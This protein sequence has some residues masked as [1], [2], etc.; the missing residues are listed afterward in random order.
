MSDGIALLS[1][2]DTHCGST[3]GLMPPE[4]V[5]LDDGGFYFPSDAQRWLWDKF[6]E[7]REA[8]E[9][10]RDALKV[11]VH[12][13]L[14]GDVTDG[15]HH[16][17]SQIVS[18][19]PN[20]QMQIAKDSL[21]HLLDMGPRT[22]TVVRGTEVHV[23]PSGSVEDSIANWI[24]AQGHA[25]IPDAATGR[26]SHWHF[27]GEYEGVL[28]DAAHHG[29]MGGRAWTRA[30][31]ALMQ[32]AEITLEHAT[33]GDRVPDLAIRSHF[34]QW[35]DSGSNYPCRV[36]QLPAFQLATAFVHRI[37][38]GKLADIGGALTI[39]R[40]GEIQDLR[41]LKYKP[42]RSPIISIPSGR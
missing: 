26:N 1:V 39:I 19:H 2:S 28:V 4:G 21:Q 13:L 17:T 41:A 9:R 6:V 18:R 34:H 23:G 33:T 27:R 10:I 37:A 15:D 25:V 11:E 3:I 5:E 40:D 12:L 8:V 24:K 35:A 36:I 7:M 32:A 38:P 29:K 31:A 30:N 20:V 16:G 22:V 14:N 42:A